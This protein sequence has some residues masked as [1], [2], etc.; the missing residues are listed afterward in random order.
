VFYCLNYGS[1]A[2]MSFAAG[3]PW[4]DLHQARHLRGWRPRSRGLLDA[5]LRARG[6]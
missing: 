5:V 1:L 2:A 3:L 6:R 4:L